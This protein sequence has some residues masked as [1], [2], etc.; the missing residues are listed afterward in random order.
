MKRFC[1]VTVISDVRWN[2]KFWWKWAD[3]TL[4]QNELKIRNEKSDGHRSQMSRRV[5]KILL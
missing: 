5:E 4:V 1:P 3:L 2:Y